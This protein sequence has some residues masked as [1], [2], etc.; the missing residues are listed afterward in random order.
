MTL[1]EQAAQ[2]CFSPALI[3]QGIDPAVARSVWQLRD[4]LLRATGED[5]TQRQ[6]VEHHDADQLLLR[7][8][9]SAY[10]DRVCR[11][12]END[13][14]AGIMVG[15]R[16]VRLAPESSLQGGKYFVAV[17][18]RHDPRSYKAEAQVRIASRIDVE[19]LNQTFPASVRIERGAEFDAQRDRVV[20]YVRTWYRDLLLSD[21]PHAAVDEQQAA[22]ALA[23]ALRPRA[24]ELFHGDPSA[25]SVLARVAL[26]RAELPEY[27]WPNWSEQELGDL[28][29]QHC[30]GK[31]SVAEAR[32]GLALLLKSQLPY[33]LDRVLESEAPEAMTVPSGNRLAVAYAAGQPPTMSVRLQEIFGWAETPR[34]ARGRVRLRVELL[35]PNYRPVQLTDDLKNFWA[36]T[37]FQVRKDLRAR[38]PKHAWPEDPLTAKAQSKGRPTK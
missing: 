14:A 3:D 37:Y 20:G 33:P 27:P 35:G 38:Y 16:G 15:G 11:R 9:L 22:I 17:E 28:I 31:R 23:E 19:W 5:R 8:V 13:A 32:A 6:P 4:E 24:V 36:T 26:L 21:D 29:V 18:L 12:R 10:P 25:D 1:L 2:S 7:L 34:I 30:Q